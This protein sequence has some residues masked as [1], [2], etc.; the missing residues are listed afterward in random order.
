MKQ[1]PLLVAVLL[2][3]L[4]WDTHRRTQRLPTAA[5]R[6]ALIR[7][8]IHTEKCGVKVS[9]AVA[10]QLLQIMGSE[11]LFFNSLFGRSCKAPR[12]P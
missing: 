9:V 1:R 3:Y 6:M 8:T 7:D 5:E 12:L 4:A 10:W 11:R 2:G